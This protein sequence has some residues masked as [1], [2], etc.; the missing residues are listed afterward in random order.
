MENRLR[1]CAPQ[2]DNVVSGYDERKVASRYLAGLT[3]GGT[4]PFIRR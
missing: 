3:E 4:I 2:D 1:R